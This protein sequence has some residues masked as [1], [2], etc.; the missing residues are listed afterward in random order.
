[1]LNTRQEHMAKRFR[2]SVFN[3]IGC[4]VNYWGLWFE[5]NAE[6]R[7]HVLEVTTLKY[8]AHGLE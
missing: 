4:G 5:F 7:H 6:R 3:L 1:M 2:M 8:A